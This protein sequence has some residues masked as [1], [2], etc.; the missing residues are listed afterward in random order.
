MKD[1]EILSAC[2]PAV[3]SGRS[4]ESSPRILLVEDDN[5]IRLL[6]KS[7]LVRSGYQVYAAADGDAAW[8]ALNSG[9][10]DL[11]ITDNH[12]PK[13]TGV[14]LLKKLHA[15]HIALPVI[16]A[17]GTLPEDEFARHP[18][19]QPEATVLLKPY[20]IEDLLGKVKEVLCAASGAQE[21]STPPAS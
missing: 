15:A 12:M 18:W 13:V 4:G 20:T 2:E 6:S 17:T 7:V 19:I 10:Y 1:H 16:M 9:N 21:Q 11:L 5:D 3:A 8:Q 14:D